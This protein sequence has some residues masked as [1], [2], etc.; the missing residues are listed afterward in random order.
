[1]CYVKLEQQLK[2]LCKEI[3]S[4]NYIDKSKWNSKQGK[5]KCIIFF[6]AN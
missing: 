2:N 1:M 6:Y 4:Q 5:M 3:H